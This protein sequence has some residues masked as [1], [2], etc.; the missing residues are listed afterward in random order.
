V[1][2]VADRR[3][4]D[5]EGLRPIGQRSA[6]LAGSAAELLQ[7]HLAKAR[8]GALDLDVVHQF[9]AVE[10]TSET[11]RWEKPGYRTN[12]FA[13]LSLPTGLSR[14][15]FRFTA[16]ASSAGSNARISRNVAGSLKGS[17]RVSPASFCACAAAICS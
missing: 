13:R 3:V 6:E 11:P 7:Q 8:I 9:L 10:E 4:L 15:R 12:D 5:M 1:Q 2:H 16:Q 14:T 17:P